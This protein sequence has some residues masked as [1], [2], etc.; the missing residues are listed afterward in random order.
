[1]KMLTAS[2]V[3]TLHGSDKLPTLPFWRLCHRHVGIFPLCCHLQLVSFQCLSILPFYQLLILFLDT[4]AKVPIKSCLGDYQSLHQWPL[5]AWSFNTQIHLPHCCHINYQTHIPDY[6]IS[7]FKKSSVIPHYLPKAAV[8]GY[9]LS[10]S[11][12]PHSGPKLLFQPYLL[13]L[14]SLIAQLDL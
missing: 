4:P 3:C 1:M 13:S 9:V 2:L 14:P 11:G 12:T 8:G 5:L 6:V 7:L 10:I